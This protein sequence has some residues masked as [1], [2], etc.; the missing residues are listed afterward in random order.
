[1]IGI[2]FGLFL[3]SHDFF[4]YIR[5]FGSNWGLEISKCMRYSISYPAYRPDSGNFTRFFNAEQRSKESAA[6]IKVVL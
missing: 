1:M 5:D 4:V 6:K 2:K 3:T